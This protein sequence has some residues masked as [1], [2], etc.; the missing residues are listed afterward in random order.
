M[1]SRNSADPLR[2]DRLAPPRPS[3]FTLVELL[4]VIAIIAMLVG[5]LIP[6][7]QAAREAGR[8]ST[9]MNT[10]QQLGKAIAGYTTSKDKFPPLFTL[11]P[12]PAL[13][14]PPPPM[15][16]SVGWVPTQGDCATLGNLA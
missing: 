10:Q 12:P 13:P 15:P 1:N 11:Q 3:G 8:R 6:A 14:T 2:T 16:Y 7:V 9:C 4:V 5:L